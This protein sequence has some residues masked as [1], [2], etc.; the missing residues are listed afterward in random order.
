VLVLALETA[1][2]VATPFEITP[3][4]SLPVVT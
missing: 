2:E 3:V 4:T 1:I